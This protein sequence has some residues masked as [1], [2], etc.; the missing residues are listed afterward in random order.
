MHLPLSNQRHQRGS[1][2]SPSRGQ[3]RIDTGY[4]TRHLPP[5]VFGQKTLV[6]LE[7]VVFKQE[8]PICYYAEG[9]DPMGK[10]FLGACPQSGAKMSGH[11]YS[12]PN[13]A[14]MPPKKRAQKQ[15]AAAKTE[16][17]NQEAEKAA[18]EEKAR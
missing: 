14:T 15:S 11:S 17:A 16:K 1:Q 3:R 2:H 4:V 5:V 7:R 18:E 10:S 9:N 8:R 12:F 6:Y 13:G